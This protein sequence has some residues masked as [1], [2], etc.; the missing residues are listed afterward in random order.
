MLLRMGI[1]GVSPH[2]IG[3]EIW[4]E[5]LVD[6]IE[7]EAEAL[8]RRAAPAILQVTNSGAREILRRRVASDMTVTL[9][10]VGDRYLG[11]DGTLY[12][13][14]GSR[15]QTEPPETYKVRGVGR[16]GPRVE[17]VVR[18]EDLSLDSLGSRRAVVRWDD[19][20]EGEALRWYADEV[21]SLVDHVG[22]Q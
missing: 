11:P 15:S 20:T 19:G 13:L 4:N 12:W 17:A 16:S 9:R 18:F 7:A 22:R 10:S 6:A 14:E 3:D 5:A 1:P 21:L 2:E 8:A